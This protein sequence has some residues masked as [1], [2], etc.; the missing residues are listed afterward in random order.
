[1]FD[2][3]QD[4][5]IITSTS[6]KYYWLT[7]LVL[8]LFG[9]YYL[10]LLYAI[11]G[12]AMIFFDEYDQE[13]E[14]EMIEYEEVMF[15]DSSISEMLGFEL[16]IED[17]DE[18]LELASESSIPLDISDPELV[19]FYTDVRSILHKNLNYNVVVDVSLS[20]QSMPNFKEFMILR[21]EVKS[22]IKELLREKSETGE[23]STKV[24]E[25]L[26]IKKMEHL[27][28][29]TTFVTKGLYVNLDYDFDLFCEDVK[30]Y[31]N[32]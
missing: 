5:Y 3:D 20:E 30:N 1:M 7:I 8:V 25:Q 6:V 23:L 29:L 18:L 12:V 24:K 22:Q 10:A 11:F 31:K 13:M 26:F 32:L 21:N 17:L 2:I 4:K 16:D 27:Y 28:V 15:S 9:Q 14:D 19:A